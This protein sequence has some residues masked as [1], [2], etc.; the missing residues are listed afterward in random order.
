[1]TFWGSLHTLSLRLWDETAE[2][3]VGYERTR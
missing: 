2:K 3:M 1:M